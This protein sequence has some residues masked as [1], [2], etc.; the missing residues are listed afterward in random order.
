VV[1]TYFSTFLDFQ[2]VEIDEIEITRAGDSPISPITAGFMKLTGL[3][4]HVTWKDRHHPLPVLLKFEDL[5]GSELLGWMD[6][7]AFRS[8]Q[9]AWIIQ[10][11]VS[12]DGNLCGQGLLLRR[13]I[14]GTFCRI[15][16]FE[17][18]GRDTVFLMSQERQ[19]IILNA[20][21]S[22]GNRVRSSLSALPPKGEE[23]FLEIKAQVEKFRPLETAPPKEQSIIIV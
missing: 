3:L 8:D 16:C 1:M 6:K 2:S 11:R 20:N 13:N 4:R 21:S 22:E 17:S 5:K 10:I 23:Q 14:D 9:S 19:D 12:F 7:I 18:K 15:G